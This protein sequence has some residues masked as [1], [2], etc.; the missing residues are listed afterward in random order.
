MYTKK[1]SLGLGVLPRVVKIVQNQGDVFI[2]KAIFRNMWKAC[3][4]MFS[5][6]NDNFNP[7]P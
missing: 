1:G 4:L 7:F 3:V 6:A 2:I 5:P